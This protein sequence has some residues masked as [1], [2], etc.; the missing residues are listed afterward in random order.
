MAFLAFKKYKI[1][2]WQKHFVKFWAYIYTYLHSQK[3]LIH[4]DRFLGMANPARTLQYSAQLIFV[5]IVKIS[6][7]NFGRF[8]FPTLFVSKIKFVKKFFTNYY[9]HEPEKC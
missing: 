6:E 4:L 5:F 8:Y 7:T 1:S 9:A 2:E 3:D